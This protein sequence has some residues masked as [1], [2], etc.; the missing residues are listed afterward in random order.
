MTSNFNAVINL[1]SR[2]AVSC[3]VGW[4]RTF[5]QI[6][7]DVYTILK[8]DLA[9]LLQRYPSIR[10]QIMVVAEHRHRLI[11][12]RESAGRPGAGPTPRAGSAFALASSRVETQAAGERKCGVKS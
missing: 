5:V 12:A 8:K 4:L 2:S 10:Q 6:N 1:P 3:I 11:K 9:R 7:T